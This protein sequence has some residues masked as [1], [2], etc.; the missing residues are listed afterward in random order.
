MEKS[1]AWDRRIE[2]LG[3]ERRWSSSLG[4]PGSGVLELARTADGRAGGPGWEYQYF[5]PGHVDVEKLGGPE[6]LLERSGEDFVLAASEKRTAGKLV[7]K[8]KGVLHDQD[9]R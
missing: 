8:M 1:F 5:K 6:D 9:V 2:L 3:M 4:W 7:Q